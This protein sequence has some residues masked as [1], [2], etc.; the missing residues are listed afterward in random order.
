M[1][2]LAYEDGAALDVGFRV[3]RDEGPEPTV[4]STPA[5]STLDERP[6]TPTK[7]ERSFDEGLAEEFSVPPRAAWRADDVVILVSGPQVVGREGVAREVELRALWLGEQGSGLRQPAVVSTMYAGEFA[8]A[9]VNAGLMWHA[10]REGNDVAKG[11]RGMQLG[12]VGNDMAPAIVE[13]TCAGLPLRI[14]LTAHG[15]HDEGRARGQMPVEVAL[16][17]ALHVVERG[18]LP[19]A[20]QLRTD[21]YSEGQLAW[22]G[23]WHPG[24][25]LELARPISRRQPWSRNYMGGY[26]DL[27]AFPAPT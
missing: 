6:P 8:T 26:L 22:D 23:T 3:V 17:F 10:L 7:V 4:A 9:R 11:A 13:R 25:D 15:N 19:T 20:L 1:A 12:R 21:L 2:H 18:V 16:G 5:P 14:F 24:F 27:N